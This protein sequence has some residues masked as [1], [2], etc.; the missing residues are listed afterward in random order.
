M[1]KTLRWAVPV[2][3]RDPLRPAA[4]GPAEAT[5]LAAPGHAAVALAAPVPAGF[6]P[7][8]AGGPSS[9]T[10]VVLG[11][12]G[13]APGRPCAARLVATTDGGAR[14][15]FLNAP[16]VPADRA[17]VRQLAAMSCAV[18]QH[19]GGRLY[20]PALWATRD[21]G[22]HWRK[23]SLGGGGHRAMAASAGTV[24]AVV[25]PPGGKPARAVRQPG[26]PRRLG[27]GPRLAVG[28]TPAAPWRCP[29]GGLVRR[30]TSLWATAD[31][32]RWHQ[33]PL[34]CPAPY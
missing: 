4:I 14:W 27:P 20:G 13:C 23:L 32:A 22:A 12:V 8:A 33:Y 6:Q 28:P 16:A 11:G 34:R 2:L 21:G 25:A 24:Y 19:P 1:N 7:V 10:G 15:R 30:S 9:A 17:H 5:G 3:A 26:G 18:R 31:G 29:A